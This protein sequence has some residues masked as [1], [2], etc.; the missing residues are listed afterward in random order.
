M[1][2]NTSNKQSNKR[3]SNQISGSIFKKMYED[4]QKPPKAIKGAPKWWPLAKIEQKEKAAKKDKEREQ[5]ETDQRLY[6]HI[7]S[8]EMR[9]YYKLSKKITERNIKLLDELWKPSWKVL[10][11]YSTY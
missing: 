9:H 7:K 3:K 1:K 6:H 4:L 8:S 10:A 5:K 2:Q 11:N